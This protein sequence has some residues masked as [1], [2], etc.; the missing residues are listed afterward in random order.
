MLKNQ[1]GIWYPLEYMFNR[2]IYLDYAA[3]S[4]EGAVS[5]RARTRAARAFAN[6]SS[7]HKDGV[8]A[9]KLLAEARASLARSLSAHSDE[10]VALSSGTESDNLAI[11]GTVRKAQADGQKGQEVH[12]VTTVIEHPAVL[13]ACRALE[14]DGV[15]VTYLAI[16]RDGRIDLK[17]LRAALRPETVLVSIAYAN[18]EIGTI[19][20]IKEIAKEIRHFKKTQKSDQYPL[21]HTDACQAANYLNLNVEQL[22]IDLLTLNGA[23]IGGPASAALLF[24]RRGTPISPLVYGGGQER[25][26]RSGTEDV[27]GLAGLAAALESVCLVK[28]KESE[29][30]TT[31]RDTFIELVKKNFPNVRINGSEQFRLPNN[32][33]ISFPNIK[34]ELLVLELDA[35]GISASAG[36]A[37]SSAEDTGS[38]VLAALYGAKDEDS[39]GSVR[40]SFGSRTTKRDIFSLI[41]ALSKIIKKYESWNT[42][43]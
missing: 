6:P 33:H 37:C 31:L 34:S 41:A 42:V 35:R 10:I 28:E 20:P 43:Q 2:R 1:S 24:V 23:K 3:L 4:P 18:N 26:L 19:Q 12:V 13:E 40:F 22:G 16:G 15:S 32:V 7:I 27:A 29:R 11:I 17:E 36:S 21:F 38:H 8:R 9:A 25:G 14:R 39:W 5:R 30:L